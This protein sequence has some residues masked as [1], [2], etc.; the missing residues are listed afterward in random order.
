MSKKGEMSREQAIELLGAKIIELLDDDNCEPTGRVQ[1]DGD[2]DEEWSSS[3][4]TKDPNG[5]YDGDN[6]ATLTAYY[7][8]AQQ[9]ELADDIEITWAVYGYDIDC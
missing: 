6:A 3:V 9:I 7:Y 1:C 4:P 2:P 5:Y 8:P